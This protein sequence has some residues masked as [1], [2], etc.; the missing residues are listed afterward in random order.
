M[1]KSWLC[2]N[3]ACLKWFMFSKNNPDYHIFCPCL[4][5]VLTWLTCN[6]CCNIP[7]AL[8]GRRKE[9]SGSLNLN[10]LNWDRISK[11]R[12]RGSSF[13]HDFCWK[14][15][16]NIAVF[17]MCSSRALFLL[18]LKAMCYPHRAFINHFYS[19]LNNVISTISSKALINNITSKG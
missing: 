5:N 1:I 14:I 19:H 6:P 13:P 18:H 17:W 4:L 11:K 8:Y 3:Q 7:R 16:L 10:K 12:W 9:N 15:T 2:A